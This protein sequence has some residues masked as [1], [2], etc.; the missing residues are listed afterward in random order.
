MKWIIILLLLATCGCASPRMSA[1]DEKMIRA[2]I[3]DGI[4]QD[5]IEQ[6]EKK[7]DAEIKERDIDTECKARALQKQLRMKGL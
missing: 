6:E 4:R 1:E 3:Q 7:Q 5:K 2:M